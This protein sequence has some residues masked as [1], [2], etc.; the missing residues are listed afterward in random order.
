M[1]RGV[2]AGECSDLEDGA[3]E[4]LLCFAYTSGSFGASLVKCCARVDDS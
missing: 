2:L 1:A 3:V 4:L